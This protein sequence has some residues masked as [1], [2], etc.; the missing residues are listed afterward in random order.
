MGAGGWKR[1]VAPMPTFANLI[2]SH[3]G[4]KPE[5]QRTVQMPTNKYKAANKEVFVLRITGPTGGSGI[6][7]SKLG[8]GNRWRLES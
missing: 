7:E 1:G 2:L 4:L 8:F 5:P 3:A 6:A